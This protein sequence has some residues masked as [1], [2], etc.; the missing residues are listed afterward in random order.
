MK[1]S[2]TVRKTHQAEKFLPEIVYGSMDGIV[3][4]FAVVAG[5]A[6]AG[7]DAS[8]VLIL[9]TANLLADGLSMSVACYLS[10]KSERDN[11]IKYLNREQWEIDNVPE[12]ER[13]EIEDIYRDKGFEGEELRIVVDRIVSNRAVWLETMMKDELGFSHDI[14]SPLLSGLSTFIAFVFAGTVPLIA[15]LVTYS[16]KSEIDSF[17][18]SSLV[19]SIAFI[20]VGY[21]KSSVTKVSHLKSIVETLLLGISA[22]LAAYM[23]GDLLERLL[24]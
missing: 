11:Y 16:G 22:A 15:Y 10:K 1:A 9:G 18:L 24:Y 3:T 17:F 12:S 6:G 21:V 13:L 5:S 4:T 14:K 8:I 20:I 2:S 7:L 23:V 19:T